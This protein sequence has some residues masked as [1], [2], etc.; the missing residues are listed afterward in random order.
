MEGT[1][2]GGPVPDPPPPE[3]FDP[4]GILRAL[5]RH[6]VHYV[7]IGGLA[8]TLHGSPAATYD[9]DLAAEQTR[10]NLQRLAVAL[11]EIGALR[12]TD[13]DE[14]LAAPTAETFIYVVESFTTPIG[15][16]DV[17]RQATAI[18]GYDRLRPRADV[19]DVEGIQILV[20]SLDDII[21]SKQATNRPKDQAQLPALRAL[22]DETERTL[23]P[24]AGAGRE[25]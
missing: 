16:V 13:P 23:N 5:D 9:V 25:P 18:G 7:L 21:A 1:P 11:T 10:D 17:F 24:D 3:K 8:G 4:I 19:K 14:P 15:Y 20:A 12:Y 2:A 6:G 22:L